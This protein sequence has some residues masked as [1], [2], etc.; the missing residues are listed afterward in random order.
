[1]AGGSSIEY[2]GSMKYKVLLFDADDTLFDFK[3]T[4]EFALEVALTKIGVDY[5][6]EYHLTVYKKV[7]T[8]IWKELEEG[9]ILLKKLKT[10]RFKRYFEKLQVE[11]DPVKFAD[12]YMESLGDGSFLFEDAREIVEE[13]GKKTRMA[14]ITNGLS[15][16]QNKRI[17]K[18]IIS[19]HFEEVVISEEVEITKPNPEI[20]ELTMARINHSDKSSVLMIG[21]NLA[22]DI[23]GGINYG[24]DTCWYNPDSKENKK[25]INPTYEV[26]SLEELK[27]IIL[28]A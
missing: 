10:E 16:V 8:K 22:S 2:G 6:K 25:G 4:E 11:F 23:Q 12:I 19:H 28:N 27:N 21:D 26:K 7:N 20:F 9:K 1:M 18:S 14:I 13:L 3:K 15:K 24:I 5:D 17:K